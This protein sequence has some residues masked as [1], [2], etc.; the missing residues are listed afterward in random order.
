[1]QRTHV[2]HQERTCSP[3]CPCS[4]S[5]REKGRWRVLVFQPLI[6]QLREGRIGTRPDVVLTAPAAS[7]L[8]TG[9]FAVLACASKATSVAVS[10]ASLSAFCCTFGPGGAGIAGPAA[11]SKVYR[12][13]FDASTPERSQRLVAVMA[14]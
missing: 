3:R 9:C 7:R 6:G 4:K 12:T 11:W 14:G 2:K 1:M 8:P 13:E 10:T 5:H